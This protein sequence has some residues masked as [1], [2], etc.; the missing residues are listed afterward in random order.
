[1]F[2]IERLLKVTYYIRKGRQ[3]GVVP[4][5]QQRRSCRDQ[6]EAHTARV[7]GGIIHGA[8]LGRQV[9]VRKS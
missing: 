7:D 3:S 8:I 5:T 1:M 2:D 6:N 4:R 9:L